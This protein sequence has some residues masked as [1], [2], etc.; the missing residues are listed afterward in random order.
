MSRPK[1]GK[2][3]LL[4]TVMVFWLGESVFSRAVEC[5]ILQF[6]LDR[7]YF[8][9]GTELD[10]FEGNS[11]EI[12][13]NDSL[14]YEGLIE[15]AILGVCFSQPTGLTFDTTFFGSCHALLD[16]PDIDSITPIELSFLNMNPA[17]IL[18]QSLEGDD[19]ALDVVSDSVQRSL[20]GNQIVSQ[21]I[22]E[23]DLYYISS[24]PHGLFSFT[25]ASPTL[26][27]G[28]T[29]LSTPAP[30]FAALIP[31]LSSTANQGGLL[32][33]SLYYRF[34]DS[35]LGR[36][37]SGDST[38]SFHCGFP[39]D[40]GCPRPYP[41]HPPTG[42]ALLS[43]YD[44]RPTS[45]RMGVADP[46]LKK[47]A[48]YFA[49]VLSRDRIRV[50]FVANPNEADLWLGF[51]SISYSEPESSLREMMEIAT[52]DRRAMRQMSESIDLVAQRIA[53]ASG[54][55][56]SQASYYFCELADRAMKEDLGIFTLFRPRLY[57]ST[58]RMLKDASF[59]STGYFH[60]EELMLLTL[61][62]EP[63][64]VQR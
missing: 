16:L 6:K 8:A 31:N 48:D 63:E 43:N 7:F 64:E 32:T 51:I 14:V 62:T 15:S 28:G 39:S 55:E 18:P 61:P 49:D 36:I 19:S 3:I 46:A 12:M 47:L 52:G 40:S 60:P 24:K 20:Y 9:A 13:L 59:D 21:R 38:E 53:S 17:N 35:N 56:S 23:N 25:P 33:T 29:R 37:F 34:S 41:Y 58:D 1:L 26:H 10:V 2:T 42:R 54:S 22:E 5:E 4:A 27:Q 57:L 11:F 30:F 44:Q 50:Q 45:I